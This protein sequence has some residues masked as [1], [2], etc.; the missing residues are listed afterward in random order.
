METL[1][2]ES[3]LVTWEQARYRHPIDR[4]LVLYAWARADLDP[5]ELA[6]EPLGRRNSTLSRL[7]RAFFGDSLR[8]RLLCPQCGQWLEFTAT[9]SALLDTPEPTNSLAEAGGHVFR[10]PTSRDLAMIADTDD[11][12][13]AALQ[14]LRL[15]CVESVESVSDVELENL[16]DEIETS[17]E[18][19]DPRADF[20]MDCHCRECGHEWGA[21]FDIASF[22]WGEIDA[23]AQRLLDEIHLLARAYGWTEAEILSLSQERRTAYLE[24]VVA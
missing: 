5:D 17:L 20:T 1:S 6:D 11:P 18:Q 8:A 15:C 21:P 14:L 2:A 12:D 10:P 3:L 23:R 7:R 24:R 13:A 19:I 9:I 4:A 16:I 22:L